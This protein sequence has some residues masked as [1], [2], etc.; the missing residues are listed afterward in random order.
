[1]VRTGPRT[2]AGTCNVYRG[3]LTDKR[4]QWDRRGWEALR[5]Q[6]RSLFGH[7]DLHAARLDDDPQCWIEAFIENTSRLSVES[8]SQARRRPAQKTI[9]TGQNRTTTEMP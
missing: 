7:G 2:I 3:R 9:D 1:M 5:V 6:H 8:L 4:L